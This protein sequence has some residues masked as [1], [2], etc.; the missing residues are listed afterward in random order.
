MSL[1]SFVDD[2]LPVTNGEEIQTETRSSVECQLL[3]NEVKRRKHMKS[4]RILHT[5]HS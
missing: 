5:V 3:K 1:R 4:Q 2:D